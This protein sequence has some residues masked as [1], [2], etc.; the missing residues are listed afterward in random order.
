M[1]GLFCQTKIS[2]KNKSAVWKK[3][4]PWFHTNLHL[5]Q[6]V[7][8]H[9]YDCI[10]C[11]FNSPLQICKSEKINQKT[12]NSISELKQKQSS[13]RE[14]SNY[15]HC[16]FHGYERQCL[17]KLK[18]TVR[19]IQAFTRGY[20]LHTVNFTVQLCATHRR[21]QLLI[22]R[23]NCRNDTEFTRNH[24][25]IDT[26]LIKETHFLEVA[27]ETIRIKVSVRLT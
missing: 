15:A 10:V 9:N 2:L 18:C 22:W 4:K 5:D 16:E 1:P 17:Y 13:H 20:S 25:R 21:C 14:M 24:Y 6:F 23:V 27:S 3:T 12:V 11:E 26:E 7:P 8:A 19:H